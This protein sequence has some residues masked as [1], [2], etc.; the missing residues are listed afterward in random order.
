V[1]TGMLH[2]AEYAEISFDG[3]NV[4]CHCKKL[5]GCIELVVSCNRQLKQNNAVTRK[6]WISK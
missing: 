3:V 1:V 5:S 2:L 6:G 4:R